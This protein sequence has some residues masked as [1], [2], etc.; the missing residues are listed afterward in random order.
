MAHYG[1]H[2][3]MIFHHIEYDITRFSKY[4]TGKVTAYYMPKRDTV[5]PSFYIIHKQMLMLSIGTD[6]DKRYT[7]VHRDPFSIEQ[8]VTMFMSRLNHATKLISTYSTHGISLKGFTNHLI[9]AISK[10]EKAYFISAYP[11]FSTMP[12]SLLKEILISYDISDQ[13][14][15]EMMQVHTVNKYLFKNHS[16]KIKLIE[17]ISKEA[18]LQ[19]L[20][21]DKTRL[22]DLSSLLKQDVYITRKQVVIHL[23]HIIQHMLQTKN[24][25]PLVI[26]FKENE[27][28]NEC[29]FWLVKEQMFYIYPLNEHSNF[30]IS[31]ALN[32]LDLISSTL[33]DM[34]E[35][36]TTQSL[37]KFYQNNTY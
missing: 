30:V 14:A 25:Q 31:D 5:H 11:P 36:S 3:I 26:S 27:I 28:L 13:Q 2:I 12:E 35:Y 18:L 8:S 17:F 32:L 33:D 19:A 34:S 9:H 1:H 22:N 10:G 16:S 21:T 4:F 23:N 24:F 7:A 20:S 29:M 6:P 37:N 15:V